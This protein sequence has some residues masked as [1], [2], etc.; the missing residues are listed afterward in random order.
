MAAVGF[1]GEWFVFSGGT[2]LVA[3]HS[4]HDRE[5]FVFDCRAAEK[6]PRNTKD[7]NSGDGGGPDEAGSDSVLAFAASPSGKLLALTDD[8]KRLV[9]LNCE[10]SWRHVSTRCVARRCTSLHFS[11]SE[12]QLL[13]A[14][15]SGDVYSFSVRRPQEE[16]RLTMGHL[17]MLLALALSPDDRF[18]ITSD[19]DEKIRVSHLR[20]PHDIQSFCLGHRQFVSA[21]LVPAGRPHLLLSGSG[22]GTVKLWDY[23][24]GCR[25][26]SC[27]L[28]EQQE[29][30]DQKATVCRISCSPD[31]RHVAVL[32]EGLSTL[33][34]FS[35]QQE[36]LVPHS[37]LPLPNCPLDMTFD[38][39]GRL[40]VLVDSSAPLKMYTLTEESWQQ[41]DTESPELNRLIEA[42]KPHW[43]TLD[44]CSRG[45]Q[46]LQ[47]LHKASG[48]D[49]VGVYLQRKQQRLD[50][51]QQKRSGTPQ[52]RR[53]K[54]KM[55]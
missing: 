10:S 31:S 55:C 48:F 44:G 46:R 32:C 17:S 51:Q 35:L 52:S 11:H 47:Q 2:K 39:E 41:C 3:V 28:N 12:E 38:P 21:L 34:F 4:K 26:Q 1:C 54:A 49:N 37:T 45:S 25:L 43:E 40:W 19:R 8:S 7:D 36:A 14:D 9:L 23:K 53:K 20:A 24:S 13:A 30:D 27:D 42:L 22:D 18:V 5:P 6:L 33:R 50:E 29:S 15:K 16:G